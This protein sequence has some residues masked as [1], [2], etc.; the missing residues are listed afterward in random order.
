MM[1]NR[2]MEGVVIAATMRGGALGQRSYRDVALRRTDGSEQ[3]LGNVLV[4]EKLGD[5][6]VPGRTGRFYFHDI[7]GSQGLHAFQPAGETARL[8]FPKLVEH[9][10]ALLAA[11]NLALV[12]AGISMSGELQMVPLTLGVLGTTAWASCRALRQAVLHDFRYERQLGGARSYRQAV[13]RG[14]A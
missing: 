2:P 8:A 6:L 12:S 14:H 9:M 7:L 11:L 4:A 10:F 3:R 1:M 13:M 5:V